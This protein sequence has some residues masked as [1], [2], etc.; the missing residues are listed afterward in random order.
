MA[1]DRRPTLA[2]SR[3]SGPRRSQCRLDAANQFPGGLGA[4]L[5][6]HPGSRAGRVVHEVDVERVLVGCVVGMVEVDGGRVQPEPTFW[7]FAAAGDVRSS[8]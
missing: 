8:Q 6:R 4:Q 2:R 3:R 7:P 1:T 5:H